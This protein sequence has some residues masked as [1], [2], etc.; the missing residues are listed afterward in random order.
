MENA[1]QNMSKCAPLRAHVT[2]L[3]LPSLSLNLYIYIYTYTGARHLNRCLQKKYNVSVL[4]HRA[5]GW[6]VF[7]PDGIY[8][9]GQWCWGY[10]EGVS[11]V[12]LRLLRYSCTI[13]GASWDTI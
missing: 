3:G 2:K 11:S 4:A 1:L 7:T 8:G 12:L 5:R 9:A 13:G 6:P 10:T